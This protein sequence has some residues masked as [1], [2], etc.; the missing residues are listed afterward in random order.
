MNGY[1]SFAATSFSWCISR[2][3]LS[4]IFSMRSSVVRMFNQFNYQE[5]SQ[6]LYDRCCFVSFHRPCSS[7]V[8]RCILGEFYSMA[9]VCLFSQVRILSQRSVSQH[10]RQFVWPL[11]GQLKTS[12]GWLM[13]DS[14]LFRMTSQR[15]LFSIIDCQP[16]FLCTLLSRQ[17]GMMVRSKCLQE[18]HYFSEK[19]FQLQILGVRWLWPLVPSDVISAEIFS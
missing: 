17:D 9:Q 6:L 1:A 3:S 2:H 18:D 4:S 11:R 13:H 19:V 15:T 12:I 10:C 8:R 16:L 5:I 14:V 7:M